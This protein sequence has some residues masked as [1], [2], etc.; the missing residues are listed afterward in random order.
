MKI[1]TYLFTFFLISFTAN[2]EWYKANSGTCNKK[3]AYLYFNK[4]HMRGSNLLGIANGIKTYCGRRAIKR[5]I[6][7]ISLLAKSKKGGGKASYCEDAPC[8]N[9][10]FYGK[11]TVWGEPQY[12]DDR[13]E[14]YERWNYW[15]PKN[16]G[17]I[18]TMQIKLVGNMIVSRVHVIWNQ[19]NSYAAKAGPIWNN[20]DAKKK[21]R[22]TCR[23]SG[24]KWNGGWWTTVPGKMSVCHCESR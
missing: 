7:T 1:I 21:C 16:T 11:K 6:A 23:R 2:A 4:K 14:I 10:Q 5:K 8:D 15:S 13:K 22:R 17:A 12:W 19:T 9:H 3:E 20:N 24:G 18:D